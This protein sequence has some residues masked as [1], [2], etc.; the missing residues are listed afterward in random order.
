MQ[1]NELKNVINTSIYKGEYL[2]DNSDDD[3]VNAAKQETLQARL[4]KFRLEEGE[5]LNISEEEI[6]DLDSFY[7]E[8]L[9]DMKSGFNVANAEMRSYMESVVFAAYKS[10]IET[11]QKYGRIDSHRKS[12]VYDLKEQMVEPDY[13]RRS[14][15]EFIL[16]KPRK[17]NL[18]MQ[19]CIEEANVEAEIEL[20]KIRADI[21]KQ[22]EFIEDKK[23]KEKKKMNRLEMIIDL[24]KE[25]APRFGRKRF[26]ARTEK[27]FDMLRAEFEAQKAPKTVERSEEAQPTAIVKESVADAPKAPEEEESGGDKEI[28]PEDENSLDELYKLGNEDENETDADGVNTETESETGNGAEPQSEVVSEVQDEP[29]ELKGGEEDD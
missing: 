22:K 27:L 23:M 28:L 8:M 7:F 16:R 18:A 21:E 20:S 11:R 14:F 1:S 4:P 29:E 3:A 2:S 13:E 17:P 5:T 12:F 24:I 6:K 15:I 26:E 19:L 10:K 25:S 9:D